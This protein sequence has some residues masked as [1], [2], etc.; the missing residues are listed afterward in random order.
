M[1]RCEVVWV[2]V[3]EGEVARTESMQSLPLC[4]L[5]TKHTSI[6]NH[7]GILCGQPTYHGFSCS[8]CIS[9]VCQRVAPIFEAEPRTV[10]LQSPV[11][12]FGDIH[13][14]LEASLSLSF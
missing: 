5:A 8:C 10:L 11:Y 13:G 4:E 9:Q 14:N 6:R 12:V 2:L 7:R 3:A 1:R